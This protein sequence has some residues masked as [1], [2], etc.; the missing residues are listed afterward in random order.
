MLRPVRPPPY[1]R[2]LAWVPPRELRNHGVFH[3]GSESGGV[4]SSLCP[5]SVARSSL[6]APGRV[7]DHS[8]PPRRAPLPLAFSPRCAVSNL[9]FAMGFSVPPLPPSP[10]GPV[11]YA[12][13]HA[14]LLFTT[15]WFVVA[16]QRND[17]LSKQRLCWP[18]CSLSA[19]AAA[20]RAS[21][22]TACKTIARQTPRVCCQYATP[23]WRILFPFWGPGSIYFHVRQGVAYSTSRMDIAT[24]L[25]LSKS[26]A[27]NYCINS[28]RVRTV[29]VL[30]GVTIPLGV[31][32]NRVKERR[33]C[34]EGSDQKVIHLQCQQYCQYHHPSALLSTCFQTALIVRLVK[35]HRTKMVPITAPVTVL[36]L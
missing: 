27:S 30:S 14:R 26:R 3:P 1:L 10:G 19:V 13:S 32:I 6:A 34:K 4:A 20:A 36:L 16:R 24:L 9:S 31:T 12:D 11:P 29:V 2:R 8:C 17:S 25:S 5:I 23:L 35:T 21:L 33:D 22:S 7:G 15:A 18:S 28:C